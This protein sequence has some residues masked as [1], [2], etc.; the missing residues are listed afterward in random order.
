M[1][2]KTFIVLIFSL[3]VLYSCGSS[4]KSTTKKHTTAVK[5]KQAPKHRT[6][7]NSKLRNN[8]V[9]T[10]K[11]YNGTKYKAAG[12]TKA[13]MDCS[14]LVFTVFKENDID[15]P[16]S[17]VEQSKIGKDLK[18]SN[19]QIGDLLFFNNNPKR[20]VI[21]HVGMVI[22]IDG[23]E[24]LFIHASTLKGVMVSSMNEDYHKRTFIKAKDVVR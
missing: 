20:N 17:S 9:S 21:N 15:L 16:R 10:A 12:T 11:K 3:G 24:I 6:V 14:G 23:D 8:L 5:K 4:K 22:E 2:L 1:S 19:V 7:S 18:L 13:G